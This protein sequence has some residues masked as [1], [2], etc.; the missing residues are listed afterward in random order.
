MPVHAV[1]F[2]LDSRGFALPAA[3]MHSYPAQCLGH[4]YSVR[5]RFGRHFDRS[6]SL[7]GSI[8]REFLVCIEPDLDSVDHE[9]A[10]LNF[11]NHP[12]HLERGFAV[13]D[14]VEIE[15]LGFVKRWPS[16]AFCKPIIA[17]IPI[18][19]GRVLVD[20]DRLLWKSPVAGPAKQPI[21]NQVCPPVQAQERN[22]R[23]T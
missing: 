14:F 12:L 16:R 6:N 21:A 1:K 8:D 3:I 9:S 17:D 2:F 18:F 15:F 20:D 22:A 5:C 23:A 7:V 19:P 10:V 13:G 4:H 11:E